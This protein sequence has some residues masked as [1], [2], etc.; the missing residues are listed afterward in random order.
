VR[1][2]CEHDLKGIVGKWRQ[3]SYS[4]DPRTT[5]WMKIKNVAYSQ[6][7]GRAELF[8]RSRAFERHRPKA[9]HLTLQLA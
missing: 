4:T 2:G 5:S 9:H 3:G 1:G 8:E 7:E 6:I